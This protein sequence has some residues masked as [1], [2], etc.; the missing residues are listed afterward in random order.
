MREG[1]RGGRGISY[2]LCCERKER[3]VERLWTTTTNSI[4][5]DTRQDKARNYVSERF[6]AHRPGAER[7]TQRSQLGERASDS[8]HTCSGAARER[9]RSQ[10]REQATIPCARTGAEREEGSVELRE[11]GATSH[12]PV[13]KRNGKGALHNSS[14]AVKS[15]TI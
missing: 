7:D 13:I 10:L 9:Q 6:L 1:R 2:V 12:K 15:H 3:Y 5:D 14:L 4:T 8:L 11:Q